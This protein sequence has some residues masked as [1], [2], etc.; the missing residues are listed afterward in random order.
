MHR[1]TFHHDSAY[2]ITTVVVSIKMAISTTIPVPFL[3]PRLL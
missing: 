1:K 2:K 3:T